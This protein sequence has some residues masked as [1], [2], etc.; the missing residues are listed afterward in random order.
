MQVMCLTVQWNVPR[1][2]EEHHHPPIKIRDTCSRLSVIGVREI[3]QSYLENWRITLQIKSVK[4]QYVQSKN[5]SKFSVNVQLDILC[6]TKKSNLAIELPPTPS[7]NTVHAC[8]IS[9][10]P[11][12]F[13]VQGFILRYDR[14][15][16]LFSPCSCYTVIRH[17]YNITLIQ[18]RYVGNFFLAV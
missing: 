5:L 11:Y 10:S 12:I 1:L 6:S 7:L 2:A 18:E 15:Y 13:V 9:R 17:V 14:T 4:A 16:S 3:N 8:I